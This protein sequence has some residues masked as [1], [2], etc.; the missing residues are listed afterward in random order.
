MLV[1][2]LELDITLLLI[3]KTDLEASKLLYFNKNYSQA[4]FFLQQSIE[5]A[6][7]CLGLMANIIKEDELQRKI[8][9]TPTKIY[10]KLINEQIKKLNKPKTKKNFFIKEFMKIR[11][12]DDDNIIL[13]LK[14]L[15]HFIDDNT[16]NKLVK[17]HKNDINGLISDLNEFI[18]EK[19]DINLDYNNLE[20]AKKEIIAL[21]SNPKYASEYLSEI[22]NVDL[23][24]FIRIFIYTSV[25]ISTGLLFLSIITQGH[26]VI[27]RYPEKE[28]NPIQIYNKNN[29]LIEN[30]TNILKIMELVL[31]KYAYIK[32]FTWI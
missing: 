20:N 31:D 5:K 9:H 18:S 2:L 15:K 14:T 23:I 32:K 3:S 22:S 1:V 10:Q 30:Y 6:T 27:S 7:K 25:I 24:R 12:V 17:I 11:K 13:M 28:M 8:S 26:V 4:I 16:G 19:S 21:H 29:P